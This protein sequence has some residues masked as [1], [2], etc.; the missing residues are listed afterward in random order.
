MG[1]GRGQSVK[2]KWNLPGNPRYHRR[3]KPAI[4]PNPV[5]ANLFCLWEKGHTAKN[6]TAYSSHGSGQ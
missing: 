3:L 1:K 4:G 5:E 2:V 6:C